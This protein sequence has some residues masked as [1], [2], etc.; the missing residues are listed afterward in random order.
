[1]PTKNIMGLGMHEI[2]QKI[3]KTNPWKKTTTFEKWLFMI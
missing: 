1:M 2:I 3:R